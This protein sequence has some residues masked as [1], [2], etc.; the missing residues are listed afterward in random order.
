MRYKIF[1]IMLIISLIFSFCSCNTSN[2]DNGKISVVTSNFP[3]YCFAKEV[4]GNNAEVTLLLP[5]GSESHHYEPTGKDLIKIQNSDLFIYTGGESD[6]WIDTILSSIDTKVNTLKM[7]DCVE[8]LPIGSISENNAN[9]E[10]DN[11]HNDNDVEYDVHVWT[12]P[13]NAIEITRAISDELCKLDKDKKASYEENTSKY[14]DSL[15]LLHNDFITFFDTVQ[16]KT[17]VFGDRFPLLYF[18]HEYNIDYA[19]AF[20]G[21]SEHSEPSATAIAELIEKIN[22][23]NISTVY[24][25]EFSNQ[26]IAN[27][28][29]E[30]TGARTAL[31]YSCHNISQE[32]FDNGE[33][34]ISLMRA[35]LNTLKDAMH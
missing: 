20:P 35:N 25:I 27:T 16:N 2:N 7:I 31:F 9:N 23:E 32:Q 17:M 8:L 24:Y 11:T 34:Y 15:N 30:A 28:I 1:S 18:A 4:C 26:N 12:S 21:C 29:S 19:S 14:I 5:L 10:K 3:A 6:T 33:D 13:I 22:S